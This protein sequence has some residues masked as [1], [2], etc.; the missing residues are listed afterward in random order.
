M[1][2]RSVISATSRRWARARNPERALWAYGQASEVDPENNEPW[3]QIMVLNR[4]VGDMDKA[5]AAAERVLSIQPKEPVA[6]MIAALCCEAMGRSAEADT[7]VRAALAIDA[8]RVQVIVKREPSLL[9]IVA[10]VQ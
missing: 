1:T 8:A 6:L 4:I 5:L 9:E 7:H 2:V 3:A 10:R